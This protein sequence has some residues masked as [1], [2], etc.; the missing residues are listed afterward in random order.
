MLDDEAVLHDGARDTDHVGFLEGIGAH[1]AAR[2]LAGQH[3]HRNRIHVGSGN[4]GNGIGRPRAGRHQHY[5]GLAGG[6]GVAV[7]HVS[8]S[9]LVTNQDV[10]HFRLFEQGIVDVQE[11]TARV[12]IDIL[13]AFV[14]QRADDH[15]SAG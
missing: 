6:A 4:A 14:T 10:R 9:L 15:F 12:P 13:N 1:H 7:S 3:H 11:G 2:H 8:G 5:T